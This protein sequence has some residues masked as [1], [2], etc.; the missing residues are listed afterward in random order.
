MTR[1]RL[2]AALIAAGL[3]SLTQA[4]TSPYYIGASQTFSH[5]SNLLRLSDTQVAPDGFSKSDTISTTS[6]LAGIDQPFG[7]QRAY[8]NISLRANRL[9]NNETF[10]NEGYSLTGGLDWETIEH[11]SGSIKATANR[12]LARFNT[13]DIGLVTKKNLETTQQIDATVRVGVVT[14]FTVEATAGHRS[15][16][17]TAAEY[18]GREF[19]QDNI[20]LG[21]RYRPSSATT[22]G[23]EVRDTK[24][25]YPKF[26]QF[27]DGTFEADRFERRDLGFT[28]YVAPSDVSS[29]SGRVSFGKTD[30]EVATERSFSGATGYVSWNWKPTGKL[31]FDT[32][33]TRDPGQDSYFFDS[34]ISNATIEYSRVTTALRVRADYELSA[35]VGLNAS[36]GASHRSLA[37]TLFNSTQ[38][39]SDRS[40]NLALGA[41]WTPTRSLQFGCDLSHDRRRGEQPLSSNLSDTTYSCYGQATLQ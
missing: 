14:A 30:Y 13:E 17:Y 10:N 32:R 34:A 1:Q 11:I 18:Q 24:G 26:R 38:T 37:S 39:G 40:T 7:R 3:C 16:D 20:S 5:D 8:G 25:K 21:L 31:R 9:S 23:V 36:V 28:A 6:L 4:E 29:F 27:T 41:L 19:R 15:V 35:K 2:L 22:L 33:L 12:N